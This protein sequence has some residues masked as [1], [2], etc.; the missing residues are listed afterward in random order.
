MG[1]PPW[2]PMAAW[3]ALAPLLKYVGYIGSTTVTGSLVLAAVL[4]A[5]ATQ[6]YRRTYG[7]VTPSQPKPWVVRPVTGFLVI[8][9]VIALE[10]LSGLLSLP[11]RLGIAAFG[12]YLA[13]GAI[14]AGGY[15][16]HLYVLAA[17]C[18]L[19]AFVPLV[20]GGDFQLQGVVIQTAFG[21]GWCLV[22]IADL[23]VV[24]KG[25]ALHRAEPHGR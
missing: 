16:R 7:V 3:V 17:I 12:A 9:T 24:M 22:C 20:L 25:F 4:T 8:V 1:D 2:L 18:V 21:L 11:V 19:A 15:R 14:V 5:L 23:R 10:I 13:W 6:W